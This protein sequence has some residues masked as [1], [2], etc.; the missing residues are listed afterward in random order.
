MSRR[1]AVVM[2]ALLEAGAGWCQAEAPADP[3]LTNPGPYLLRALL[4]LVLV[5]GL[6]YAAHFVA[7]RVSGG[8]FAVRSAGPA[9]L[10][11]TLPLGPGQSLHVVDMQG[12][13]W[14]IVT[15]PGGTQITASGSAE[16]AQAGG[17]A[18]VT[19]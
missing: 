13:R 6:I 15:G 11:Q 14:L 12:Q 3:A 5:V 2:V 8:G 1:A 19:A 18:D 16:P 10:V 9:R 7:R 17:D 4:S